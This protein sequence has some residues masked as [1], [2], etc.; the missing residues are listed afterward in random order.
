EHAIDALVHQLPPPEPDRP[1]DR[2]VDTIADRIGRLLPLGQHPEGDARAV[3]TPLA[4]AM[5]TLVHIGN[6]SPPPDPER[7]FL[8]GID[9]LVGT[10]DT[11]ADLVL[12]APRPCRE[13]AD[14]VDALAHQLLPGTQ[15]RGLDHTIDALAHSVE[16]LAQP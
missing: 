5:D 7:S 4:H 10:I 6:E 11:L 16:E 9:T 13:L 15:A 12:V 14:A 2:A 8:V 1:L 3:L